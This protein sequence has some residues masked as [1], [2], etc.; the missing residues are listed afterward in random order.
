MKKISYIIFFCLGVVVAS[1][2]NGLPKKV[3]KQNDSFFI[4]K[5]GNLNESTRFIQD[6]VGLFLSDNTICKPDTPLIISPILAGKIAVAIL[7]EQCDST[8]ISLN[9]PFA[10]YKD[11]Q[12]WYIEGVCQVK[13]NDGVIYYDLQKWISIN[14]K[15]AMVVNASY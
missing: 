15:D 7:E 4:I 5:K 14:R 9:Y 3:F 1:L 8:I 10:I 12:T 6:E 13:R 11:I 2:F